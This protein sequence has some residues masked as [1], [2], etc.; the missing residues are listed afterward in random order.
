MGPDVACACTQTGHEMFIDVYTKKS[1]PLY[2]L[3]RIRKYVSGPS[4]FCGPGRASC[5][6]LGGEFKLLNV[7]CGK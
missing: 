2:A 6:E 5:G 1:G 3:P 7:V 4:L